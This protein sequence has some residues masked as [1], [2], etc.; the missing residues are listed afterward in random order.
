[1]NSAV[2]AGGAAEEAAGGAAHSYNRQQFAAR[3]VLCSIWLNQ[4]TNNN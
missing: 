2:G 1:M 4:I 3:Y